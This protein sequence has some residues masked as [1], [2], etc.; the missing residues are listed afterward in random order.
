MATVPPIEVTVQSSEL[1]V[2]EALGKLLDKLSPLDLGTEEAGKVEMVLAEVLNNIVEHAYPD[3]NAAGR[4]AISC[5]HRPDGL[6]LRIV[7]EGEAMP[8]GNAPLGVQASL[9]VDLN[10]LPEGGFGWFLIHTLAKDV[11]Y[12]RIGL[13][14][15]LSMRLAVALTNE[16][17]C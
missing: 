7:D 3:Q 15:Q 13:E 12:R 17:G 8:G 16:S 9:D 10:D 1:A 4:I 14:N 6:H 5:A 2:R 11:K